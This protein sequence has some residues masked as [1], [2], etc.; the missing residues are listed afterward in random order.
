[1]STEETGQI[2]ARQQSYPRKIK[3]FTVLHLKM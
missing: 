1:V 2:L 3:K